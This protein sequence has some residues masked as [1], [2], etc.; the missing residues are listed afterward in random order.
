MGYSTFYDV[1]IEIQMKIFHIKKKM[2]NIVDDKVRLILK[3]E[4]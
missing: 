3:M 1:L 2:L 4:V